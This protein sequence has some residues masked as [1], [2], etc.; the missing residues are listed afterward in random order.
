MGKI[1]Q[2]IRAIKI[3]DGAFV[4]KSDMRVF[5]YNNPNVPRRDSPT[6]TTTSTAR[7]PVCAP[8]FQLLLHNL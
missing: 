4:K 1:Y 2:N 6:T 3:P 5:V 8:A 7:T